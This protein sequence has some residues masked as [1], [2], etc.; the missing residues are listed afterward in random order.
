M[1]RY[2]FTTLCIS[3]FMP[4]LAKNTS[5]FESSQ[6][7][8]FAKKVLPKRVSYFS[9]VDG[10]RL[11]GKSSASSFNQIALRW[12]TPSA[13]HEFVVN[14]Q[15]L[16]NHTPSD[17]DKRY[18]LIDPWFGVRGQWFKFG[19]LSAFGTMD[20]LTPL[21]RLK[22]TRE[23]GILFNPGG[24][25]IINYQVNDDFSFGGYLIFRTYIYGRKTTLEDKRSNF[26]V[27]PSANYNVNSWFTTSVF[28]QFN[29]ETDQNYKTSIFEDDSLNFMQTF[30]INKFLTF[31]PRLTFF[32]ESNF[33][34]DKGSFN[35]WLSGMVF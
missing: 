23:Q 28:Y 6:L 27:A 17:G 2:L 18:I 7:S 13:D 32:R 4:I 31:E 35:I 24:F 10:P 3:L 14:N 8:K 5:V 12:D 19:N 11:T 33:N 34:I 26:L 20:T 30:K 21:T 15:F 16:A 29:G 22:D 1:I 9:A 25:N